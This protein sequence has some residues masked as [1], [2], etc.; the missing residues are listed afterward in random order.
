MTRVASLSD[1]Y[2]TLNRLAVERRDDVALVSPQ[3]RLTTFGA[4]HDA[5]SAAATGLRAE[6]M[7]RGDVVAFSVRPSVEAIVLILATVRAGGTIVAADPGM[8]AALF[9]ARMVAVRPRFVMAESLLYMLSGNRLAR[10]LLRGRHLELPQV[11]RMDG[12]RFV[13]V[14]RWLPG[15]PPSIAAASLMRSPAS[16]LPVDLHA[17]DAVFVVFTSGTTADPRAVVHTAR[18]AAAVFDAAH[19]I[20]ELD[21][22][23]VVVTDQLHS[24]LPALLAGSRVV[25]PPTG[26]RPGEVVRLLHHSRATHAFAVPSD[27]RRVITHCTQNSLAFP[28]TIRQLVLGAGPVERSLLAALRPLLPA[29]ARVVSVYGL[30]EMAPVACVDMAEKLSWES[31]GDLVGHPLPDAHVRVDERGE[32]W[33]HGDRMCGRYLGGAALT[34]VATGDL[35]R[36][37]GAGRVVLLGRSK[38]MIIR[39]KYNIYPALFEE[40]IAGVPGV[41]RCAMI[42]VWDTRAED[43]RVVLVAEPAAG[44]TDAVRLRRR[45]ERALQ[46]EALVADWA[47]PDEVVVMALPESGRAH[48]V[49]RNA[50]RER[51]SKYRR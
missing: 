45:V 17:D 36:I 33:V 1:V 15:T 44:E 23:A 12:C 42:G 8:G 50:L 16:G 25:I 10:G 20:S 14:G 3:G 9:S 31:D 28:E 11:G 38:D 49:D 46:R 6:G 4:L 30:T 2:S 22:D 29:A 19:L 41:A 5:V 43:E 26:A 27:L 13:R 21:R 24:A 39:G 37:D 51:L 47:L 18:S 48:K 7:Q 32:L 35:A 34:E 40:K